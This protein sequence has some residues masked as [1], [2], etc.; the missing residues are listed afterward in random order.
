MPGFCELAEGRGHRARHLVPVQRRCQSHPWSSYTSLWGQLRKLAP[1]RHRQS[2]ASVIWRYR[3]LSRRALVRRCDA[4]TPHSQNVGNRQMPV[5]ILSKTLA[6]PQFKRFTTRFCAPLTS[7]PEQ[8]DQAP[9]LL[10]FLRSKSLLKPAKPSA[11]RPHCDG[12]AFSIGIGP[13]D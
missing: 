5:L 6:W 13:I 7:L 1:E 4:P 8:R 3:K 11:D 9:H 12:L 2:V 10:I